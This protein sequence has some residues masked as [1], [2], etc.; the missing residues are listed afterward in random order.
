[1]LFLALQI[2]RTCISNPAAKNNTIITTTIIIAIIILIISGR[3]ELYI[4]V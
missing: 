2:E 3:D 1:M 4:C